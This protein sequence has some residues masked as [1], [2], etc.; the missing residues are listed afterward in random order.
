MLYNHIR[1]PK[2]MFTGPTSGH[3]WTVGEYR[4]FAGKWVSGQLGLTAAVAPLGTP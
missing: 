1:A 3:E 2:R 4:A